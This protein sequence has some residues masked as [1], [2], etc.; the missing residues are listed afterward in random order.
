MICV[1]TGTVGSG[2]SYHAMYEAVLKVKSLRKRAGVV[3]NF[4]IKFTER[5]VKKGIDKRW[6]FLDGEN[7]TPAALIRLSVENDWLGHESSSLLIIDE[8]AV[9]FNARDWQLSG[10]QRMEWIK[11][12]AQSRKFGYDVIMI[13]QDVRM[14]DRQIRSIAEYTVK[15]IKLRN[16]IWLKLLPVQLFAHVWHWT[17]GSFKGT[18][19]FLL[20]KPWVAKRYD[21]MRLF[22]IEQ[23]KTI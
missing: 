8:A 7:L 20:Y 23:L 4:P 21:T 17:G 22:D 19:R 13:A 9:Y 18:V 2:K 10:K 5:E 11:F 6:H 1:Y 14:I 12:F 16:Y 15:H 3:A